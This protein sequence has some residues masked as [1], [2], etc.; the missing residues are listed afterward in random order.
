MILPFL[1]WPGGKRWLVQDFGAA[2]VP[3]RGTYYEP[4]LG[5]GA[6]FFLT[7]PERAHLSDSNEAL[8]NVY[9]QIRCRPRQFEAKLK[10]YQELHST[11][12]Y[13]EERERI[14][15]S[16]FERAVQFVYLNRTCFNG[17]YRVNLNGVFN[18]PIG[19]KT[20]VILPTD[21]FCEIA[22]ALSGKTL[23]VCGYNETISRA[24]KNDF[25][26]ADPPYTVKHNLNGFVKYN[27][28][29]FQW[30]D[31]E[32]LRDCLSAASRRGARVVV[33]NADHESISALYADGWHQY[34]V[35]R[36]SV[37]SA[38][39]SHRR[40]TTELLISNFPLQIDLDMFEVKVGQ[41]TRSGAVRH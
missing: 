40:S 30:R 19:S 22:R 2:F 34:I 3:V 14:Y 36:P 11:S 18:V 10:A 15:S 16:N 25:I 38:D 28:K 4:F 35:S 27:E 20:A 13:Y 5:A 12:F 17:I 21:D 6:V 39:S 32:L 33:S 1:K 31:Q 41:S 9:K 8:I 37:I 24:G 26:Y 29:L 7:Q 23:S